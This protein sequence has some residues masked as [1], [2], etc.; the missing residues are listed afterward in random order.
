M[1]LKSFKKNCRLEKNK[2][3]KGKIKTSLVFECYS[4]YNFKKN[5]DFSLNSTCLNC[6]L[7]NLYALKNKRFELIIFKHNRELTVPR[8][9]IE[10]FKQF[11]KK[12]I[13]S[14]LLLKRI[15]KKFNSCVYKEF[16]CK[17]F[18]QISFFKANY[19]KLIINPILLFEN[20]NKILSAQNNYKK[21]NKTCKKCTKKIVNYG[22]IL[23]DYMLQFD[24]IRSYKDRVKRDLMKENDFYKKILFETQ[25]LFNIEQEIPL[26]LKVGKKIVKDNYKI[27]FIDLFIANIYEIPLEREF[28][29]EYDLI[30]QSKEKE[31]YII[32]VAEYITENL[33]KFTFNEIYPL[34]SLIDFYQKKSLEII[35]LNYDFNEITKVR[36][37]YY[38][39]FKFLHLL[40]LF[41]LLHDNLIEEIFLDSPI[42]YIYLNHRKYGRCR[43]SYSLSQEDIERVKTL[44]RLYSKKRIDFKNPTLK[45]VLNNTYFSCRFS[46][47][48]KPI[49]PK[50][51]ALTIRKFNNLVFTLPELIKNNTLDPMIASFLYFCIINRINITTI[52][53]TDSG[54]TTLINALDLLTPKN[55]RKIYIEN[56]S[57]SLNQKIYGKHQLKYNVD[58]L[59]PTKGRTLTKSAQ[60]KTLLHRTPD[61]IYLGEILTR[62]EAEAMFHCLSAGLTGFQTIHAKSMDSFL[63]RTIFHFKIDKECLNDLGVIILMKKNFNSERKIISVNEIRKENN[64]ENTLYNEIFIYDPK[65][66]NW[67]IKTDLYK[68][69]IVQSVKKHQNLDFDYFW[70]FLKHF[71]KIFQELSELDEIT[72]D[73][74]VKEFHE[75]SNNTITKDLN[76]TTHIN[77]ENQ[78][79]RTDTIKK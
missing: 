28:F 52:G 79:I 76:F 65:K 61:L 4:C 54:K 41:P 57:E 45:F 71:Y 44:L 21:K 62:E 23:K 10:H 18:P 27:G 35:D 38:A 32:K 74:I 6:F 14:K 34:E 36:I 67:D 58:S 51:F 30:W 77:V 53:E 55:F 43:T 48:S 40:K 24:I 8:D 19:K 2:D 7:I 49:H 73:I 63:N 42:D 39:T 9:I 75:I 29:Y 64:R 72:P 60:I 59:N 66:E 3:Y 1:E 22:K 31:S 70:D 12:T 50:N 56:I 78:E 17:S 16:E 15:I 20:I 25:P 68:T 37:S 11:L 33:K 26:N 47:D 46:L 5:L 13:W 69:K